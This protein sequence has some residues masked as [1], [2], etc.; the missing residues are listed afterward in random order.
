MARKCGACRQEGHTRA[1]CPTVRVPLEETRA[2]SEEEPATRTC[3]CGE[4][5]TMGPF[6]GMH[7]AAECGTHV[8]LI[9]T[10]GED[11]TEAYSPQEPFTGDPFTTP[12]K[13]PDP[14]DRP[15][16]WFPAGYEQEC[17]TCGGAIFQGDEI[18]A[19]G[20]GGYECRANCEQD[21]YAGPA[22]Y[23]YAEAVGTEP[24]VDHR[25]WC[26]RCK[27]LGHYSADCT[28][29]VLSGGVV[30]FPSGATF[31]G[32]DQLSVPV[33]E[34]APDRP[35]IYGGSMGDMDDDAKP[36]P[37]CEQCDTDSHLCK[38]CGDPVPHGAVACLA[39][40]APDASPY[41]AALAA[42]VGD[43]G[44]VGQYLDDDPPLTG[45]LVDK[46]REVAESDPFESPTQPAEKLNV[47]GQPSARYEWY[48]KQ[49]RGYLVKLPDTGDF[50]RYK[51]GKPKGL[52]RATTFNKAA[53][54]QN[55]LADWA[56]RNV[57]I[58]ASKRPDVVAKA[59]GLTH[60]DN[61]DQL[62]KLVAELETTAGAKVSA[63]VGTLIHELT[64]RW[65]AGVVRPGDI[66]AQYGDLIYLYDKTLKA[67]GLWPV[68]GLI[69][70]TTYIPEFGGVVGTLDRVYYHEPSGQ[71]VIGD[72][73]TGKTL[74]YGMDEI[75]TQEWIYAH[76][77][78]L[79][80]VYDW[81]TDT[82]D[83]MWEGAAIPPEWQ[84]MTS[85]SED[86][87]VVVHMPV[88]GEDAGK[89]VL[90]RAD[91]QRGKQHAQ[92]CHDVR[93]QRA[94]KPKPEAWTGEELKAPEMP[95]ETDWTVCFSLVESR[96]QAATWWQKAYDAGVPPEEMEKLK[97]I[98]DARLKELAAPVEGEREFWERRFS[99]VSTV[100]SAGVTWEAA[101]AAGVE[102]L[103][104][105]RLVSLAQQ[106]L[107]ELG[108]SG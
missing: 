47:S 24:I 103:E 94:N 87:G 44:T 105:N 22:P 54:D 107:R 59:H 90:V 78:N 71:Y 92:V 58:G 15:G 11:L 49:N 66:P 19:D 41:L 27:L 57:L 84:P 28:T 63:D 99:G 4:I 79:N 95:A 33:V 76:G 102:P 13:Q 64:E 3:A 8:R 40:G 12:T 89:V 23:S 93:V 18:R 21:E 53:T 39:C 45:L 30:T 52:T 68:P 86:W 35:L 38:G 91:L 62:M 82:W 50:R 75:E 100:A 9:S 108:I 34:A 98:A 43:V 97:E 67:A 106:R 81:N 74:K 25:K 36:E 14:F 20:Q 26:T 96:D 101:R 80:G 72:V 2:R 42:E 56:K 10:D 16:P 65:D 70:R 6:P 46:V 17:D 88:Q 104:L 61:R 37:Y 29:A 5:T 55:A 32:L 31:S 7:E 69:E 83:A 51:N 60:E 48:G 1:T 85:V 73:K 77:V